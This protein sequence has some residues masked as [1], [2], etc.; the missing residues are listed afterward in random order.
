V[1]HKDGLQNIQ[2]QEKGDPSDSQVNVQIFPLEGPD[3]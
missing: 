2:D 3:G 1:S